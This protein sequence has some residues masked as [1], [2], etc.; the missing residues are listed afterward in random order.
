MTMNAEQ[1]LARERE[2]HQAYRRRNHLSLCDEPRPA[3]V[4]VVVPANVRRIVSSSP[5][6]RCGTRAGLACEHRP[7]EGLTQ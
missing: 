4:S 1:R 5:C 2:Y 3:V 7:E 6:W